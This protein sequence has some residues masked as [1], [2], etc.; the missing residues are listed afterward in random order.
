[1]EKL[2]IFDTSNLVYRSFFGFAGRHLV[3]S[4]GVITSGI[5]GA[6]RTVIRLYK[7]FSFE[8]V[9]FCLDGP[10]EQT[11]RFQIYKN[12]K[13]SREKAPNDLKYQIKET[14]NL[15]R[16]AG[17]E[18][19]EIVGYESDDIIASITKKY[20]SKY[21]IYIVSGDKDLLQLLSYPSVKVISFS[22]SKSEYKIIDRETFI[23]ENGFEPEYIVDFLSLTGDN[24]DDIP[25]AK[26]IGEKTAKILITKYKTIENIYSNLDDLEPSIRKK[27]ND[28][29]EDVFLSKKLIQL[30][31]D[32]NISVSIT[33]FSLENFLKPK[34]LEML[35]EYEFRS[36]INEIRSY[37]KLGEMSLFSSEK[38]QENIDESKE[39]KLIKTFKDLEELRKAILNSGIVSIDIETDEKHFMECRIIGVAFSTS[40]GTGYYLPL[41]H[42]VEK[43][44]SEEEGVRFLKEIC[45][46]PNIK[47]VGHNVKYE[48]VVMKRYR[49]ELKNIF[50]DT[51]LA[52]YTLRPEFTHHN[53][54][55]LAEEYLNYTTIKYEEVTKKT[56][57]LF[58]TLLD[59]PID[60][61]VE[62]SCEDADIAL[63]LFNYFSAKLNEN[64]KLKELF[65]SLEM[66]LIK[67]LGEMEYNGIKIDVDYLKTLSYDLQEEIK[68]VSLKIFDLAGE[69][70]NLNSPK[71]MSYIL[72]DKLK[73]TPLKRTKTGFSTDEEVLEDLVEQHEIVEYILKHRTL[74]KLKTTYVDELPNMVL[75]ST[76]RIHTSFNQAVTATG[77]LSSSNPNLQNIPIR[78]E[79]G[80][81]IRR[82]FISEEGKLLGSFDYSQI[83]LRVLAH[84]SGDKTLIE[85][86]Y[87]GKD[88]HSETASKIFGI[89]VGEV[90]PEQRRVG[91]TVNFG[92]VY[93]ISA[94]GL[95]KQLKITP[96]EANE[97]IEKYFL[98]YKGIKDYIFSTLEFASKNGYVETM[99]GRRRSIPEL[100]NKKYNSAKMV[101]GKSERIAINTPI[102]G[103]AADIVKIAM[104][105]LYEKLQNTPVKILLQVHDEIL[106]EIPES[107]LDNYKDTIKDTL[108]K[109]VE[110][111]V[112]LL[113]EYKFGKNWGEIH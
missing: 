83:E 107:E 93:G 90:S 81:K 102:Q 19:V 54:D 89:D 24:V 86:F 112:P 13:V 45:E 16:E 105:K 109:S 104:N 59:V 7:D 1:M 40:E 80:R 4:K 26:G 84:I 96:S 95:S 43:E 33:K 52:S 103:S 28:S 46:D 85:Q 65:Y 39:Y 77:R 82:A 100:V 20:H 69:V 8:N 67:V 108:E 92:I 75:K 11:K 99:F 62:Y 55:R 64:T 48:Y 47:K 21:N 27:V 76:G 79:I 74:T 17:I 113:V 14:V 38:F 49:I 91:K 32:E 60:E 50:F 25:G 66:P 30:M 71:Q 15:L 44:F 6:L 111:K 73:L 98:T 106:V 51:M 31:F 56:Q 36:I 9:V 53:L 88:I 18:Y 34:A 87:Q 35:K 68:N 97:I 63:R 57:S 2:F 37:S 41:L 23:K 110:L 42:R 12:Y 72:F 22:P 58:N 3:N 61:V 5:F 10:R 78:D 94:Y 101:F 70:F 29:K